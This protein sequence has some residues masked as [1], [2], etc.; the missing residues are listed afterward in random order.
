MITMHDCK[1]LVFYVN[2]LVEDFKNETWDNPYRQE[3]LAKMINV[4]YGRKARP[5]RNTR[6]RQ[7]YK[8]SWKSHVK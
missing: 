3:V 2:G 6:K 1:E 7:K 4:M 8:M 5:N